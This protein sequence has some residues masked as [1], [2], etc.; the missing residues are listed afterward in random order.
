[1]TQ[2]EEHDYADI[3]FDPLEAREPFRFRIHEGEGRK[4]WEEKFELPALDDPGLPVQLLELA[5]IFLS[6]KSDDETSQQA[7]T[8]LT[9]WLQDQ[10]PEIVRALNRHTQTAPVLMGL[11]HGWAAHS[12]ATPKA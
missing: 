3:V 6:G 7:F 1:M 11:I 2:N 5:M 10:H 12:A 9:T 8:T 4:A